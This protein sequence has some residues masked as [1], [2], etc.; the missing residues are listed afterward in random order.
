M[1]SQ[2]GAPLSWI[3]VKIDN[4][5]YCRVPEIHAAAEVLGLPA[6]SGDATA[7]KRI[8]QIAEYIGLLY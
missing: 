3:N 1:V 8:R 6:L 5:S 2:A 7:G 4:T